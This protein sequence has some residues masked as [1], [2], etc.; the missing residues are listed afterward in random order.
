M[1]VPEHTVARGATASVSAADTEAAAES[2]A[3]SAFTADALFEEFFWRWYSE[4]E[5]AARGQPGLRPD[6]ESLPAAL[7][8]PA[9]ALSRF[10][11]EAQAAI[12]AQCQ[13]MA[14]AASQDFS[15]LLDE[16]AGVDLD[17]VARL[18]RA[19]DVEAALRLAVSSAPERE[20]NDYLI[21][22]CE[23]GSALGE[24][25]RRLLPG[26]EWVAEM[27]YWDSWLWHAPTG[28]RLNPFH[29]A[30]RE[31]S[32]SRPAGALESRWRALVAG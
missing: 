27:P 25:T 1:S 21:L 32:Q 5:R 30:L 3:G 17:F 15:E 18:T 28:R 24:A 26:A 8:Q 11:P 7:G 29:A 14:E 19:F 12:V 23:L 13:R 10:E 31:L 4:A 9:S 6:V 16:T 22:C 20:P 2:T